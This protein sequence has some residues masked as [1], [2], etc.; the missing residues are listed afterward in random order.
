MKISSLRGALICGTCSLLMW[1]TP[2]QARF[3]QVDPI[4]YQD[5]TNLYAYVG[6]DP[7]NGIDPSGECGR[8]A[9]GVAVGVCPYSDKEVAYVQQAMEDPHS[10]IAA[11]D[12]EAMAGN[13]PI[14]VRLESKDNSGSSAFIGGRTELDG[15]GVITVTI[16]ENENPLVEGRDARTGERVREYS[17]SREE[18][19]EHEIAGE[20]RAIM[21]DRNISSAASGRAAVDAENRYR[22][23]RGN[24][25]RRE[26][27]TGRLGS[28]PMRRWPR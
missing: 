17:Q 19:S 9:E 22:E 13:Q 4:G 12:A 11:T 26:G 21:R 6:N 24:S 16:D 7:V 20:A 10:E 5:Q 27:H 8:N 18:V 14:H 23:R 28:G 15:S 2:S 1:A 3:L 25:F